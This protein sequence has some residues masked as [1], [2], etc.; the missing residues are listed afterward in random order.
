MSKRRRYSKRRSTS[1]RVSS[2]R[3]SK[4]SKRRT[5]KAGPHATRGNSNKR[6]IRKAGKRRSKRS[7]KRL[8]TRS[9]TRLIRVRLRDGS[10]AEIPE[11]LK[12][13]AEYFGI[14]LRDQEPIERVRMAVEREYKKGSG[15]ALRGS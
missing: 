10:Y 11:G 9:K 1:R 13:I 4:R 3:K 7:K 2:K 15:R 8:R 6:G 14:P 12:D 5:R